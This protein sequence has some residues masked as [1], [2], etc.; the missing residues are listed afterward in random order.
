MDKTEKVVTFVE[1]CRSMGLTLLPP[2]VNQGE[3][4]F[5]VDKNNHIIYGLGAIKGL[6][7]GPVDNIIEARKDGPFTSLFAIHAK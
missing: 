5:T 2:D 1:E 7:E 3:F 6:G 4:Q